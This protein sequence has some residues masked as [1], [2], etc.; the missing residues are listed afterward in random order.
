MDYYVLTSK[1]QIF[2]RT[3][4]GRW[5]RLGNTLRREARA[6]WLPSPGPDADW[7][8]AGWYDDPPMTWCA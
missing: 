4:S 7:K 5:E 8:A 3:F 2:R 1:D 6:L